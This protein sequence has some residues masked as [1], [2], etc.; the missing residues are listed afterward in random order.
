MR[1]LIGDSIIF[2]K[3][4]FYFSGTYKDAIP[5]NISTDSGTDWHLS[6]KREIIGFDFPILGADI[7]IIKDKNG[8]VETISFRFNMYKQFGEDENSD[9]IYINLKYYYY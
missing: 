9:T 6:I 3:D 2:K 1:E 5:Y 8:Y 4:Y 7:S